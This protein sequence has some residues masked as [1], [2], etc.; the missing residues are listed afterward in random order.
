M[1]KKK[2]YAVSTA[3]LDTVWRWNLSR[4]INE[5]LPDTIEK[6]FNLIEK[7]PYYKFNFEGA[8][9]YELIEEFYPKAFEKIKEYVNSGRWCISG[10]SY[11]SGDVNIP[12]PEAIFRNFLLGDR[13]YKEKFKKSSSDVFL[14]D[15]F[16]F[17]WALPSIAKHCGLNGFSTQKLSWGSAY[18]IPFDIGIWE[19]PDKSRIFTSLNAG[20]YRY[21]FSGDIRGDINIISKVAANASISKLPWTQTLYGTG[22]QGGA[23]EESSVMAVQESAVLNSSK[24][25][26][27]ISAESGSIFKD[28]EM[29]DE[30]TKAALPVWKNELLMTSHGAGAYTS[31]SMIKRL[32]RKCESLADYT[33]KACVFADSLGIMDYP[34]ETLNSA[35]KRV[36]RH[37]FHDDITGTSNMDVYNDTCNDY[38]LSLSQ[39]KNEYT[40]AVKIIANELDTSWIEDKSTALI[41]NNATQ[42]KRLETVKA[43]VRTSVNCSNIRVYDSEGKE[44]PSQII[45]KT[46]KRLHIAFLAE[47]EPFGYSTYEVVPSDTPCRFDTGLAVTN[48]TLE[49]DKFKIKFNKNGDIAYLLDKKLNR[50]IIESPIKMAILKDI[51]SLSYP[52]WEITKEDIDRAPYC[53]ANTPDF[54]IIENGPACIAVKIKREAE[55]SSITQIV[56]LDPCSEFIRVENYV[57]WHTRRSMLKAVFPFAAHNEKATYDIGL[58]VIERGTNTDTLYEVPAQKWADITN[59]DGDF[60]VSVFSDSKYGWDKPNDNTLRL[61]C[62]HTPA[63]A[64]TKE[65]R[66]DLQDIGRNY[67]GFG[68]YSHKNGFENATQIQSE[69]FSSPLIAF[70]TSDRRKRSLDPDISFASISCDD[71]IVRAIKK[72]EDDNTIV[73]RVNEAIGKAHKKVHIKLFKKIGKAKEINALEKEIGNGRIYAGSLIFDIEP[74]E[75]KTFKLSFKEPVTSLPRERYETLRLKYNAKGFTRADNMRH[76]ILQGAGFSLPYEQIN[77]E[78]YIGG[79]RFTMF[80]RPY[81]IKVSE[82]QNDVLVCRGQKIKIPKGVTKIYFIAGSTLGDQSATFYADKI[83]SVKTIHAISENVFQWDLAGMSQTGL[84][85]NADL[86]IEFT[87]THHPEG[88]RAEKARFYLYGMDV[89]KRKFLKLP[90]NNRIII[91]AMTGL[92]EFS[93]ASMATEILDVAAKEYQFGEIP[94]IDKIIDKADFVSI[95]AGKIQEQ[96]KNGKGK[97]IKRDNIITNVIRSYTK[98]EW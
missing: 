88:M 24:D 20:S 2:A 5:F 13:Y 28:M 67:F 54:S 61:T 52:S 26:D 85:K 34:K 80:Q 95:R 82:D 32:N 89:T 60:G 1:E 72:C 45:S 53:Y 18:G 98:S 43:N 68:I 77:Y 11:E 51:G 21:K 36:I 40:G 39:F 94:P 74:F 44:V 64:F 78:T 62:I 91:L 3:H 22:D 7:Y 73:I 30:N 47:V 55:Y 81:S 49:N 59:K 84:T 83:E 31:R 8:Y 79:I 93:R 19:G 69:I 48:H 66:Q 97:G 71:V 38:Y 17:G 63:G 50:Q 65:A 4:T 12:S 6:N 46:G 92:K 41:V 96:I 27:V 56:S 57:H 35:W 14:P 23:P 33:E 16:G 42:F 75:V 29:L 76:T 9:R 90:E 25:F 86:A 87:H 37:Q 58:G 10:T 70:Q 15:C